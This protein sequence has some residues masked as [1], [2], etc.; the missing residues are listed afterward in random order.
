M[1]HRFTNIS[2]GMYHR[3]SNIRR[4]WHQR[5][6]SSHLQQLRRESQKRPVLWSS[7]LWASSWLDLATVSSHQLLGSCRSPVKTNITFAWVDVNLCA[8]W[9]WSFSR[10]VSVLPVCSR[11]HPSLTIFQTWMKKREDYKDVNQSDQSGS[12]P[13]ILD[14]AMLATLEHQTHLV[15]PDKTN[16]HNPQIGNIPHDTSGNNFQQQPPSL[17][18]LVP[19]VSVCRTPWKG[20][21]SSRTETRSARMATTHLYTALMSTQAFSEAG[22]RTCCQLASNLFDIS[23]PASFCTHFP[24]IGLDPSRTCRDLLRS[25]IF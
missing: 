13:S 10:S 3:F 14:P 1:D 4:R 11:R 6:L 22:F 12:V 21:R 20:N 9:C 19:E 8:N 23:S 5:Q 18:Q 24:N 25:N 7:P 17:Q 16:N 2:Q 15:Q